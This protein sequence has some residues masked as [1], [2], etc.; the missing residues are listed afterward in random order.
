MHTAGSKH[1]LYSFTVIADWWT[2]WLAACWLHNGWISTFNA[3]SYEG[4]QLSRTELEI[5]ADMFN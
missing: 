3:L 1:S 2:D 4:S 5:K